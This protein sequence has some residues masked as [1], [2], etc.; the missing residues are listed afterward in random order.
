MRALA[1]ALLL[2][3]SP[4]VPVAAEVIT[5]SP[6]PVGNPWVTA[7]APVAVQ[8]SAVQLEG[9]QGALARS[10]RPVPRPELQ[11][12]AAPVAETPEVEVPLAE[13]RPLTRR[14]KRRLRREAASMEGAVCGV[15]AIKGEA[16]ADIGS[17]SRGCGVDDPVRVT[18]VSGVR[19]SQGATVDCSVAQALNTWVAE[20]AQPA[21]DGRLVELEIAAHYVCRSRNNQKG[22]PIS[23]HG[24]GR[25]I[26]I[27]GFVLADGRVLTVSDDFNRTLKRIYRAACGIFRTT[28]GPGSDGF[29]ENHFHFDTA[30]R[31]GGTYCR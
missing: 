10:P 12:A 4:A 5:Q 2:A 22:A 18:S 29:H 6:R 21:F 25:A 9:P 28:L 1:L 13:V 19:L 17:P 15:P 27:S 3:S 20:V 23:E 11:V 7:S 24:K 30:E 16:I 31:R 26:D 8:A 14:E